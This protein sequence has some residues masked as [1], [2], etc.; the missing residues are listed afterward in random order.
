MSVAVRRAALPDASAV[1]GLMTALGYPTTPDQMAARLTRILADSDYATFVAV[2]G[3]TIDGMIGTRMGPLYEFD[4]PYGQIM[5]LVVA[6]GRRRTGIG[7]LLLGAAEAHFADHGVR[8]AVVTSATR[9]AGAHAFYE[10]HGYTFDGR[11]YKKPLS[12]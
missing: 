8:F 9:R 3:Q 10:K 2:D 11:R 6:D 5:V 7:A 4:E 12:G 1:A